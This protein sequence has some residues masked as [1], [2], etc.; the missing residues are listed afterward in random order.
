[1]NNLGPFEL[2]AIAVGVA[3]LVVLIG[4]TPVLIVRNLITRR[5]AATHLREW[6]HYVLSGA[7]IATVFVGSY[8]YAKHKGISEYTFVKW[9]NISATAFLVFGTAVKRFWDLRGKWPFWT[10]LG[11]LIVGH[12]ALLSRLRWGQT[13]Y[14]WLLVI[15]G[16]PE[17]AIVFFLLGLTFKRRE[18]RTAEEIAAIIERFLTGQSLYPQEWNDFVECNERNS[19]LDKYRQRCYELDPLVNCPSQQDAKAV[20]ELRSMIDQLRR[21]ETQTE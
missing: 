10:G 13:R 6:F 19:Q 3:A 1:M 14:F 17:I 20:A 7:F 12:F 8:L 4:A 18:P 9:L 16:L 11:V 5:P 15:V 21:L 2:L